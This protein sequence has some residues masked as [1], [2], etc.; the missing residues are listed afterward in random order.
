MNEEPTMKPSQ[1]NPRTAWAET[2]K[3]RHSD[4]WGETQTPAKGRALAMCGFKRLF[5]LRLK[6]DLAIQNLPRP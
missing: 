5:T 2:V 6:N 3:V 1:S 4:I